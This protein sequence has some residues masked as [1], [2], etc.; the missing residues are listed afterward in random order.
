MI[1]GGAGCL[2]G[3]I[4]NVTFSGG[5]SFLVNIGAAS[6]LTLSVGYINSRKSG[7]SLLRHLLI[8]HLKERNDL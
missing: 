6:R 3:M 5:A 1:D 7:P 2:A 4:C 8:T